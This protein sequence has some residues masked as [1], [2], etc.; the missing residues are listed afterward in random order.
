LKLVLGIDTGGTYTDAVLLDLDSGQVRDKAKALTTPHDLSIGI[1]ASLAG[2]DKLDS[3]R[4]KLVSISTTLATNAIV[5]GHGGRVALLLI[6]YD[7]EIMQW[8][9][10]EKRLP[11]EGICYIAGGHDVKGERVCPLD[12]EAAHRAI[13]EFQDR[14]DAFA[15][16]GYFSV[17]NPEHERRIRQLIADLTNI[18]VVCGHELTSKLN[19]LK[20]VSTAVLN[21]RLLP[22]I[23]HLLDSVK[24]VLA[25]RGITA[26]LM[27][28]KG[29]GSLITEEMARQRPVETIL[30]GPAASAIGGQFL[31]G[32]D[33]AIVVDMGG[34]TTDIAVLE[35]GQPWTNPAGATVGGWQT[36]VEAA[37]LRT[38][39]IGGDSHIWVE[40]GRTLRVGPR[41]AIPLCQLGAEA[42][43]TSEWPDIVRELESAVH[44]G[45]DELGPQPTD[46]LTIVR[47][48]KGLSL[49]ES[50]EAI[51]RA[52]RH[53]PLS[54]P[55]LYRTLDR[56]Y[57]P[58]ER[59]E[60]LGVLRR[61]GLTPT[62]LLWSESKEIGGNSA[63]ARAGARVVARQLSISVEEL[64]RQVVVQVVD[65]VAKEI[66]DKLVHDETGH[67][68]FPT[69]RAWT[70]LLDRVLGHE[71]TKAVSCQVQVHQPI[72]AIGGPVAGFMPQV[73]DKLHTQYLIPPHAEVGNAVGAIVA[74]ITQTVEILVQPYVLGAS[75][76]VYL[77]HSPRGRE[78]A[79]P[80]DKAVAR[81]EELAVELARE[82]VHEAGTEEASVKVD[83]KEVTLGA[84][85]EMTI[86]ATATGRPRL[87]E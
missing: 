86:R 84:L 19:S 3:Q 23:Q 32:Q 30:S 40:R 60:E 39:G 75:T 10:L 55:R 49:S 6:G 87:A 77:I 47:P 48:A 74:G 66:L 31:A 52:L 58:S 71:N 29:D 42:V 69:P 73:A 50:E 45:A 44:A 11:V 8:S 4:V 37:D 41:R 59:L 63:A 46:F 76:V 83:R 14:V 34:T 7:Q 5:E 18:P 22:V 17:M 72:V 78:W 1:A 65:K 16:S 9:D 20:R 13:L 27:V 33:S 70:F 36:S 57:I 26:P 24:K 82:A 81:A 56:H 80:F 64:T 35:E 51:L 2:L 43:S 53:G 12:T 15:V 61:A 62:D 68:L 85:S 67:S 25:E 38:I 21:A 28:V 79:D 54:I